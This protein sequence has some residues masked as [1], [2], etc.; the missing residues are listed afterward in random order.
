M[1]D[2]QCWR[3]ASEL[4]NCTPKCTSF[5]SLQVVP[6]SANNAYGMVCKWGVN[7]CRHLHLPSFVGLGLAASPGLGLAVNPAL[8]V[9]LLLH[10]LGHNAVLDPSNATTCKNRDEFEGRCR[11]V[12]PPEHRPVSCTA[13][14]HSSRRLYI[15]KKCSHGAEWPLCLSTMSC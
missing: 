1:T 13:H 15:T 4:P 5:V 10:H 6:A 7:A 2:Q 12:A 9:A 14:V 3:P 8:K 11:G